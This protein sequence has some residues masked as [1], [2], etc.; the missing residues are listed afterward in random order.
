MGGRRLSDMYD[1][2]V[3]TSVA[4]EVGGLAGSCYKKLRVS[5]RVRYLGRVGA[6]LIVCLSRPY[7][8]LRKKS[9]LKQVPVKCCR[10]S[11]DLVLQA[12]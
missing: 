6:C 3:V 4:V 10:H 7:G 5:G 2:V 1:Q 8:L 11:C 12:S 9:L